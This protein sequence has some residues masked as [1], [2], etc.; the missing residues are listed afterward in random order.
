MFSKFNVSDCDMFTQK[1][2][3]SSRQLC[4]LPSL[5]LWCRW[6]DQPANHRVPIYFNAE[7]PGKK[8]HQPGFFI[9]LVLATLTS[10]FVP[11]TI[12]IIRPIL[13]STVTLAIGITVWSAIAYGMRVNAYIGGID[14]DDLLD[15]LPDQRRTIVDSASIAS[16]RT[17][18]LRLTLGGICHLYAMFILS[19]ILLEMA[20]FTPPPILY[21]YLTYTGLREHPIGHFIVLAILLIA[22]VDYRQAIVISC[23]MGMWLSHSHRFRVFLLLS[24][25]Q[26]GTYIFLVG[27]MWAFNRLLPGVYSFTWLF[28]SL[29][30]A[31]RLCE[32][33]FYLLTELQRVP[34]LTCILQM[35][36]GCVLFTEH[37]R[38]NYINPADS[39]VFSR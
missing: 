28:A 9:A 26:I 13:I 24:L 2:T 38:V 5:R 4:M 18:D 11:F 1:R 27:T 36:V 39:V 6:L 22:A 35:V 7:V 33:G 25:L 15:V 31:R 3:S 14:T 8:H 16:L 23:L 30:I 29:G 34:L 20:Y 32:G 37:A 19:I 10:V 21:E 17:N 12:P